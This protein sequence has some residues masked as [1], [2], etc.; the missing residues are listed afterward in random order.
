M[1]RNPRRVDAH[2]PDI[3]EGSFGEVQSRGRGGDA[4][5]FVSVNGLVAIRIV[6]LF[7]DIRR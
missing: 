4:A 3:G 1:E 2:G 7:L 5:G 6:G